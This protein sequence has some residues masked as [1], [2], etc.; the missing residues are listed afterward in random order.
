MSK[1]KVFISH[2][3]K[4]RQLQDYLRALT[5]HLEEEGFL[6]FIDWQMERG[7]NWETTIDKMMDHCDVAIVLISETVFNSKYVLYEVTNLM[8]RFRNDP[9]FLLL[10]VHIA[11]VKFDTIASSTLDV[12]KIVKLLIG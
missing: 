4:T 2:S 7:T 8:Q 12:T 10:P 11:P 9:F 6:P 1:P 3:A 5:K